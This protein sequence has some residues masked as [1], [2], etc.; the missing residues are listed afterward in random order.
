MSGEERWR[1]DRRSDGLSVLHGP[2]DYLIMP[3]DEG[4]PVDKCPCCD[5]PFRTAQEARRVAGFLFPM[6]ETVDGAN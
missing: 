1:G 5:K 3:K 6:K 2:D 4:L